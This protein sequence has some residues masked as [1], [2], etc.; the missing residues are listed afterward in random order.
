MSKLA[1]HET[2]KVP[3]PERSYSPKVET[4]GLSRWQK[5]RLFGREE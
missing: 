2:D 5:E 1:E 4:I 3:A